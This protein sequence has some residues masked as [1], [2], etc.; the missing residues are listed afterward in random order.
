VTPQVAEAVAQ[1]AIKE[2]LATIKVPPGH[3]Y[4]ETWQRL[5]GGPR[6]RL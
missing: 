4:D 2:G 6:A 1:T 5:F 3:V